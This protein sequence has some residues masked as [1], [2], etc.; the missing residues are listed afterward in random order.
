MSDFPTIHVDGVAFRRFSHLFA[1]S[2]CGQVLDF[3]TV[4]NAKI[5]IRPDGYLEAGRGSRV[6]EPKTGGLL[7]RMVAAC[8]I[9]EPPVEATHVHHKN[10]DKT[11]NRAENLEWVTPRQHFTEKH[12]LSENGRYPRS[13]EMRQKLRDYRTGRP[14]SEETKQKQREAT[15]QQWRLGLRTHKLKG[16]KRTDETKSKMSQNSGKKVR[17]EVQGII[18]AS[19]TEASRAL[20]QRPLSLRKRCLSPNFPEYRLV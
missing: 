6:G 14:T 15:T 9:A 19:F 2:R 1:V 11:D 18:Y 10:G 4:K 20:N 8:W 7:H 17:C 12:D 3:R 16:S 13:E 5:R